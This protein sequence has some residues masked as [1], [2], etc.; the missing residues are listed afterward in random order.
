[1]I[2][3]QKLTESR[4]EQYEEAVKKYAVGDKIKVVVLEVSPEKQKVA[5]SIKDYKRKVQ[6]E[7]ISRYMSSEEEKDDSAYTLG[8]FLKNKTN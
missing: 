3:K 4:E 8:D 1:M 5:F 2:N 7:E 6:R